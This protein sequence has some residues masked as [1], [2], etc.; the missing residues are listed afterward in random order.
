MATSL[1][2][3]VISFSSNHELPLALILEWGFPS[4]SPIHVESLNSLILYNSYTGNHHCCEFV[5]A[6]ALLYPEDSFTAVFLFWS[7]TPFATCQLLL[8]G[9]FLSLEGR[10]VLYLFHLDLSTPQSCIHVLWLAVSVLRT[11]QDKK[12][13]LQ[14]ETSPR[15]GKRDI[16]LRVLGWVFRRQLC[17]IHGAK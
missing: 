8:Q 7:L 17:Y 3:T 6:M 9:C 13:H 4:L 11:T 15:R 16:N 10:R 5:S 1:K 12:Y 14:K 2:E